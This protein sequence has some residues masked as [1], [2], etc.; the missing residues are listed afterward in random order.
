MWEGICVYMSVE[1]TCEYTSVEGTYMRV[2]ECM[3]VSGYTCLTYTYTCMAYLYTSILMYVRTCQ[4]CT[5]TVCSSLCRNWH[6][7]CLILLCLV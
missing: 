6:N 1:G 2:H 7:L 3:L 5:S 4:A